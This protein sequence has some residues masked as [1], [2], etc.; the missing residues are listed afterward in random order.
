MPAPSASTKPARSTLNGRLACDGS[1]AER[2]SGFRPSSAFIVANPLT[3]AGVNAL[4][5]APQTAISASPAR[6]NNAPSAI[7][8]PPE[9]QAL[10][11]ETLGPCSPRCCAIW[12]A[13]WLTISPGIK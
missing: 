6:R 12:P 2:S 4:S 11:G 7:A 13:P 5:P 3:T 8:C 1:S 9:A 10:A